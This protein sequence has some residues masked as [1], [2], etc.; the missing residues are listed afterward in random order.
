M[1]EFIFLEFL[2]SAIQ[3][4]KMSRF[5]GHIQVTPL[6]I[7]I[8]RVALHSLANNVVTGPTHLPQN[9]FAIITQTVGDFLLT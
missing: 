2:Q 6:Q 1:W 5:D 3:V 7:A 9:P 8:N 4:E